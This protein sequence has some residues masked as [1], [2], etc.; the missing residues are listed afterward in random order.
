MTEETTTPNSDQPPAE[1][2]SSAGT[3]NTENMIPQSRF[4][5][6]IEARRAAEEKLQALMAEREAEREKELAEQNRYQELYTETQGKL[7]ELEAKAQRAEVLAQAIQATNEARIAQIPED[8]RSIVPEYDDPILLASWLDKAIPTLVEPGRPTP[9]PG[10]GGAGSSDGRT[11][12]PALNSEQRAI[13]ELARL[14]GFNVDEDRIA[15]QLK[16]KT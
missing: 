13:A 15:R 4:N 11:A 5:E 12:A 16:N 3:Q 6:V 1:E 9:P 8:K 10:D 2:S 7:T 14:S